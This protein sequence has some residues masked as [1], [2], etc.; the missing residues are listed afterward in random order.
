[1]KKQKLNNAFLI[2]I[3]IGST[4]MLSTT[5]FGQTAP[6]PAASAANTSANFPKVTVN[7]E[8][9]SAE[10]FAAYKRSAPPGQLPPDDVALEQLINIE[11]LYQDGKK[12][13]VD[14]QA[15]ILA[16]VENQRR[17]IIARTV[18][19]NI[20]TKQPVTDKELDQAY[21]QR[22][23]QMS[24]KEYK[25][26]H[27]L[28]PNEADAKAIIAELDKG[29]DFAT[30]AKTKSID[31]QQSKDAGGA[32][33]WLD[34]ARVPPQVLTAVSGLAAKTYTKTPVQTDM[35]WHVF[36]LDATRDISPPAFDAVKSQLK[37][38]LENDRVNAYI[39][40]L[41]KDGAVQIS[42]K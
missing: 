5:A 21:K 2:A 23:E 33:P 42:G 19:R 11:L 1:M 38:A 3:F 17:N 16:D 6:P 35:G 18:M 39:A 14:K 10:G 27:I 28:S 25:L 26:S 9:I 4:G 22:V 32:L 20:L 29:Q 40:K 8:I 12:Q 31:T 37:T 30:L 7:K 36:M 24:K 41:K 34:S 15:D 13:G